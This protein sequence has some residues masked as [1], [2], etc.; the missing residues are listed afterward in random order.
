M[1]AN[2]AFCRTTAALPFEDLSVSL[3]PIQAIPAETALLY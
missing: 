3:P 2:L 1:G